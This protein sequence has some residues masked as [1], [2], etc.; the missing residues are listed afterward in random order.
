[1]REMQ[2][3]KGVSGVW[4]ALFLAV[5]EALATWAM[6]K[7]CLLCLARKGAQAATKPRKFTNSS[8]VCDSCFNTY[9]IDKEGFVQY[10]QRGK[11]VCQGKLTEFAD[12]AREV[13]EGLK[14][15]EEA[16]EAATAPAV[17]VVGAA[18]AEEAIDLTCD[19]TQEVI[20]LCDTD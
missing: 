17:G 2:A 13:I 9:T 14:K 8:V 20:D 5:G 19:V 7:L 4:K 10:R 11:V 18:A 6:R 16:A 1:M 12:K 15:A 3:A